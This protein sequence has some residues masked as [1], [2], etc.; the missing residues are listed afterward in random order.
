MAKRFTLLAL[1][2]MVASSL[3][4]A[5]NNEQAF[6]SF[7]VF[8]GLTNGGDYLATDIIDSYSNARI[9]YHN[10]NN[11]D[12]QLPLIP[13]AVKPV[14]QEYNYQN[15]RAGGFAV[16]GAG[17]NFKLSQTVDLQLNLGYH[18]DRKQDPAIK[19]SRFE[20]EAIP[21][22]QVSDNIRIGFGVTH[23]FNNHFG[24]NARFAEHSKQQLKQGLA[25][26][27]A[28]DAEPQNNFDVVSG[29]LFTQLS[30]YQ[31]L[32]EPEQTPLDRTDFAMSINQQLSNGTGWV[33]S[34]TYDLPQY[35]SRF[36]F[37]LVSIS[38][39]LDTTMA[40]FERADN[41]RTQRISSNYRQSVD[42]NHVGLYYHWLF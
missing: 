31:Q 18:W 37:R 20:L 26:S 34:V 39:Y 24:S 17:V 25:P 19:L 27:T 23:H 36:E 3:V 40:L 6:V 2:L 11:P 13:T 16:I 22:F 8:G 1:P 28:A 5:S 38:Y 35:Q 30:N 33:G 12:D 4:S 7:S 41:S 32:L 10:S 21:Y 15:L 14:G 9:A 29:A 42:G